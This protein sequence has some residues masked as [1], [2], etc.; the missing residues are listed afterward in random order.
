MTRVKAP[1][2]DPSLEIAPQSLGV[3]ETSTLP[4]WSLHLIGQDHAEQAV[5]FGP[6]LTQR[7]CKL[8]VLGQQGSGHNSPPRPRMPGP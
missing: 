5:R 3:A 4:H 2:A 8:V 6:Q 7:D 1:V